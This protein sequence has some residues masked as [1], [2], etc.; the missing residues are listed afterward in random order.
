[1]TVTFTVPP[2]RYWP[3]QWFVRVLFYFFFYFKEVVCR[4][5]IVCFKEIGLWCLEYSKYLSV[6]NELGSLPFFMIQKRLLFFFFRKFAL[7]NLYFNNPISC[8][9]YWTLI[10]TKMVQVS[11][12]CPQTSLSSGRHQLLTINRTTQY[13]LWYRVNNYL[14]VNYTQTKSRLWKLEWNYWAFSRLYTLFPFKK[15]NSPS[16]SNKKTRSQ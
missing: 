9:L 11:T 7:I 3:P 12:W 6:T 8:D 16:T 15:K 5:L 14:C 4:F 1:M 13:K 10:N 2:L